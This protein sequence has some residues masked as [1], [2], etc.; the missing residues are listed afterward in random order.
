MKVNLIGYQ[1]R[2]TPDPKGY[3]YLGIIKAYGD[4]EN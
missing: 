4:G 1:F 2:D 3:F